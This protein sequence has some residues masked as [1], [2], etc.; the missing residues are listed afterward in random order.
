MANIPITVVHGVV[1]STAPV[2]PP[3]EPDYV[4][5]DLDFCVQRIRITFTQNGTRENDALAGSLII[6]SQ[7]ITS[8]M[9]VRGLITNRD[10]EAH[11]GYL[12]TTDQKFIN[13]S[14]SLQLNEDEIRML[15][16]G[17]QECGGSF[18]K[19]FKKATTGPSTGSDVKIV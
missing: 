8:V 13:A 11:G 16:S 19:L 12:K 1:L 3:A 10:I 17:L 18:E 9:A 2:G 14:S 15:R 5:G 4:T 7:N 6:H